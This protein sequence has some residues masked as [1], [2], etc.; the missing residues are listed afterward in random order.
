MLP[1][2]ILFYAEF[3]LLKTC[4]T[5]P[6]HYSTVPT[7]FLPAL[8]IQISLDFYL[9]FFLSSHSFPRKAQAQSVKPELTFQAQNFQVG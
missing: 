3:F 9:S 1:L 2:Q 4:K 7:I 8:N 5:H 6:Y